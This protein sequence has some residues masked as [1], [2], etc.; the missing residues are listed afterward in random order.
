MKQLTEQLQQTLHHEIPMTVA[1]GLTVASYDG[2]TLELHA[3]LG[4]NINHKA[5]AFAGSLNAVVTLSGWGMVW[6]ILKEAG[7]AAKI[8]IQDSQINYLLPVAADF[9][10]VCPKPDPAQ[11]NRFQNMLLKRGLGRLELTA[12]IRTGGQPAVTFQGRYVAQLVK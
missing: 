2:L 5:T 8:V 7:I 9:V 3:P 12:E 4:P 1:L 11:I 10:A 6:C